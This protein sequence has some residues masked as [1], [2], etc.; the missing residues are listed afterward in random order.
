MRQI[1]LLQSSSR[2]GKQYSTG[3]FS[4]IQ[5]RQNFVKDQ[6][7]HLNFLVQS[8]HHT[9]LRSPLGFAQSPLI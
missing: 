1:T 3:G 9:S 4:A 2:S 6:H 5:D 7:V 8:V